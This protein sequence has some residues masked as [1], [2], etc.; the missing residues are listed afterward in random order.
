[1]TSKFCIKEYQSEKLKTTS[2]YLQLSGLKKQTQNI[3]VVAFK[4]VFT[5]CNN[6]NKMLD[7][8]KL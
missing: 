5:V 2:I 3:C 7:A 4:L 1:M 6:L 8:I